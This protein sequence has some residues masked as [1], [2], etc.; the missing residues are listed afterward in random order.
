M[1]E[2]T[3]EDIQAA[4]SADKRF[5]LIHM[6]AALA[7]ELRDSKA[8]HLFMASLR[9]EAEDALVEFADAN[10]ANLHEIMPL[11]VRVRAVVFLNRTIEELMAA[12]RNAEAQLMNESAD[13]PNG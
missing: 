5:A 9:K 10:I 6:S 1:T 4:I 7:A 8:L 3:E 13:Y 11:Q 2:V 12:S